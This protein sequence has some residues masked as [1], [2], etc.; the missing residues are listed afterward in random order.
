MVLYRRDSERPDPIGYDKSKAARLMK[1]YELDAL[2]VSSPE[3]VFYASGLPV[4]H[5][6]TNP[7]LF[8]LRNQYPS[9]AIIHADGEESLVVWDIYDRNLTW[10]RDTRGCL[11]PKDALRAL[12]RFL[13]KRKVTDGTI[14]IESTLP[15]YITNFLKG[16]F[17]Q[18]SLKIGD[19]LLLDLQLVKSEEEIRRITESTRMAE[20]AISNMIAATKPGI[21]DLELIQ[22]GKKSILDEGAEGWDHFTFSI[23]E[24]DPEAPGTGIKV[25]QN[26]LVRYDIGAFYQGYVSDVNRYCYVGEN[27]PPK[28]KDPVDAII[29]V[30]NACEKAIKPGVDPK[31]IL[32]LS[33]KTWREAGRQD[34]FIIMAHSVGLRT[35]E[36]HFFDPM[37]G[38]QARKFEKGNV[39]DLEAWT[40]I[41]NF[42]TVGNEDTYVVTE[43]GCKRISTLEMKIFQK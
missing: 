26:D 28:V 22:L 18:A 41:Q 16:T 36:F 11:T 3:N 14:G 1:Q 31:E 42:G 7:I 43:T 13:K 38:G 37:H 4:R 20:V 19:D 33:E 9:V 2:I 27:I 39:L 10:I 29:Q 23:G 21:S 25:K 15:F 12:K 17:P 5:H 32:A 6:A 35:E 30:Q 40:L 24:S 34:S 8:A